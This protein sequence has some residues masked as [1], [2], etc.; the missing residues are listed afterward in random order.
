ML[1]HDA[2][3]KTHNTVKTIRGDG[4]NE[5][6]YDEN[7]NEVTIDES[8]VT[9]KLSETEYQDNRQ[10]EYPTLTEQLDKLYHDMTNNKLDTTGEWHKAV[11][12]V[13]DKYPKP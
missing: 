7:D 2:I 13:K 5:R 9:A 8:L 1:R 10:S 6:C 12:S 11:K 4:E 3:Y